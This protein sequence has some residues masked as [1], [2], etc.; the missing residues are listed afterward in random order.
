[1]ID[2]ALRIQWKPRAAKDLERLPPP[3]QRRVIN[4]VE[5][6]SRTKEGDVQR[7]TGV[8]P[9]EY[10]LRVGAYRVRF[11]LDRSQRLMTIQRVLPRDKAYKVREPEA[12]FTTE[13]LLE[14][15]IA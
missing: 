12:E 13:E 14:A 3:D 7:L 2:F 10:R 11:T 6:Y 15:G 4:A 5:R 1:M 8:R 9:P